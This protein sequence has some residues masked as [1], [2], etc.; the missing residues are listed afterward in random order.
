MNSNFKSG[1]L[2]IYKNQ[3]PRKDIITI[4]IRKVF[5]DDSG[6]EYLKCLI[7]NKIDTLCEVWLEKL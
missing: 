3:Y 1:E 6:V 5:Q 2:A 4:I 7:D